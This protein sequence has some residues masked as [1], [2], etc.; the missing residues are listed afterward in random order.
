[1]KMYSAFICC[2]A[3]KPLRVMQQNNH[4]KKLVPFIFS[5][6]MCPGLWHLCLWGSLMIGLKTLCIVLIQQTTAVTS[7]CSQALLRVLLPWRGA[8]L[9]QILGS[10][11]GSLLI[12]VP[13]RVPLAKP[14][15]LSSCV[16]TR[17]HPQQDQKLQPQ[18]NRWPSHP[19]ISLGRRS[20]QVGQLHGP[21][22]GQPLIGCT[23]QYMCYPLL[24]SSHCPPYQWGTAV[25][26]GGRSSHTCKRE[27][28]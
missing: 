20:T 11:S 7:L 28:S 1:M 10:G 14:Q 12:S 16:S 24:Q 19:A 5:D 26:W 8:V 17:A 23:S 6:D 4:R 2:C 21:P 18:R 15:G 3:D 22:P 9:R 13:M 25:R 27:V